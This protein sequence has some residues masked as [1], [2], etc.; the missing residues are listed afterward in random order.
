M[1]REEIALEWVKTHHAP[2]LKAMQLA[3]DN[4]PPATVD[5]DDASYWQH[6]INALVKA[7]RGQE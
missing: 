5:A 2:A 6:E 3:R 7:V 4:S 1:T